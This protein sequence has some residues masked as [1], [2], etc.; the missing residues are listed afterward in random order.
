MPVLLDA[1]SPPDSPAAVRPPAATSVGFHSPSA[2]MPRS[3]FSAFRL[4]QPSTKSSKVASSDSPSRQATAGGASLRN[5]M[6]VDRE[7]LRTMIEGNPSFRGGNSAERAPLPGLS[8]P[9]RPGAS[10]PG[11]QLVAHA[12]VGS[13]GTICFRCKRVGHMVQTCPLDSNVFKS[14]KEYPCDMCRDCITIGAL[15]T[16]ILRGQYQGRFVHAA[17]GL[18][19][20]QQ[21]PRPTN[22][23]P[24]PLP[25]LKFVEPDL[26]ICDVTAAFF[27]RREPV[28]C[29]K[30]VAG[31]G[32]TNILVYAV[33]I[34][35]QLGLG[36]KFLVLTFNIK[37]KQELLDRGVMASECR[38]YTAYSFQILKECI[39]AELSEQLI[40]AGRDPET[41]YPIV[42]DQKQ[43][44]LLSA[45]L[46][47]DPNRCALTRLLRP[48]VQALADLARQRSF[49]ATDAPSMFDL[50]ELDVLAVE[51]DLYPKIKNAWQTRLTAADMEALTRL[52]GGAPEVPGS[53]AHSYALEMTGQLLGFGLLVATSLSYTFGEGA[54]AK[55]YNYLF[56]E[57]TN[58]RLPLPVIDRKDMEWVPAVKGWGANRFDYVLTD[59]TQDNDGN[60]TRLIARI[61]PNR[62]MVKDNAQFMYGWKGVD[63]KEQRALLEAYAKFVLSGNNFRSSAPIN[64]YAQ[65]FRDVIRFSDPLEPQVSRLLCEPCSANPDANTRHF[66]TSHRAPT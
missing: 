5:M 33:Q 64:A 55:T 43:R 11:F 65:S 50:A 15:V 44:L 23:G 36:G 1:S 28:V 34:A 59:E 16:K 47:G 32:K 61:A 54:A 31:G 22:G 26:E 37:A 46:V 40:M 25:P 30:Q 53:R 39:K 62:L 51:Y 19:W 27:K 41:M 48:F 35:R 20:S 18:Q 6:A 60:Q 42:C 14:T 13:S 2:M 29:I 45:F 57:V 21:N 63:P 24:T 58:T 38:T 9:L 10:D 12:A 52:F 4:T 49:G 66:Q 8:A 17:C 56:N 3:P 7:S